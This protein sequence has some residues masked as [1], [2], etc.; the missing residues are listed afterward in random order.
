MN[1]SPNKVLLEPTAAKYL[2]VPRSWLKNQRKAGTGPK[3]FVIGTAI[4]YNVSDLSDFSKVMVVETQFRGRNAVSLYSTVSE[5][6]EALSDEQVA[7]ILRVLT[8]S[9]KERLTT[10][11]TVMKK[12]ATK[13][14]DASIRKNTENMEEA[15]K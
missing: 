13:R 14:A 8:P 15:V 11:Q 4:C 7:A 12:E 10:I 3:Y 9:D 6:V 5:F 1:E 2:G